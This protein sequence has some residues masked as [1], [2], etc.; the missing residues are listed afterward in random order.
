MRKMLPV[1]KLICKYNDRLCGE[2][3]LCGKC[4]VGESE[5][6]EN[7]WGRCGVKNSN[8]EVCVY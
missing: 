7:V 4:E 6:E 5:C 1:K 3:V 2:S 8:S